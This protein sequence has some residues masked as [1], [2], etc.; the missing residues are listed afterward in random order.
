MNQSL[1]LK[2]DAIE[3]ELAQAPTKRAVMTA[4]KSLQLMEL[5]TQLKVLE[6]ELAQKQAKRQSV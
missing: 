5:Q 4:Q 3:L 6:A 2:M 1:E